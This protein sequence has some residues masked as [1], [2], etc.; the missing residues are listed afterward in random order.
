MHYDSLWTRLGLDPDIPN[1]TFRANLK[2]MTREKFF[3]L[4]NYVPTAVSSPSAI[5]FTLRSTACD[6]SARVHGQCLHNQCLHNQCL[7]NQCL[8]NQCLHKILW[9]GKRRSIA[10]PCCV[11]GVRT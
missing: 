4:V 2:L 9:F 1:S 3:W 7:H 8:H 11:R 5:S 6:H 10:I